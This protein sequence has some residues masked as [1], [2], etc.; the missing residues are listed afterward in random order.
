MN[1]EEYNV[2]K[3]KQY[4]FPYNIKAVWKNMKWGRGWI[5]LGRKSRF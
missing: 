5:V 1:G 4:H 3:G 2:G